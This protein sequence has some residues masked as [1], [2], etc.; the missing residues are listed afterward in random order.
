MCFDAPSGYK[1]PARERIVY[2]IVMANQRT[3]QICKRAGQ[4]DLLLTE[5]SNFATTARDQILEGKIPDIY[6]ANCAMRPDDYPGPDAFGDERPPAST[7]FT[8]QGRLTESG[9]LVSDRWDV[10]FTLFGSYAGG[11]RGG[12][13]GDEQRGV[14][15]EWLVYHHGGFWHERVHGQRAWLELAVRTNGTGPF[16]VLQP[17]QQ[18]TPTPYALFAQNANRFNGM[19]EATQV[20]VRSRFPLCRRAS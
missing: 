15:H 17:R 5:W 3:A 8:Y 4:T 12:R 10:R 11:H 20:S 9:A 18:I 19:I 2:N 6:E 14:S 1:A 7:A 16:V 13:A